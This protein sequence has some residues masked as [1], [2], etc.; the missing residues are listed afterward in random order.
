MP[1]RCFSQRGCVPTRK[2]TD[3]SSRLLS[4]QRKEI[5]TAIRKNKESNAVLT[6]LNSEL[7]QQFKVSPGCFLL[8]F[9]QVERRYLRDRRRGWY[10]F[11]DL[12]F[13]FVLFNCTPYM[14]S[15]CATCRLVNKGPRSAT[16]SVTHNAQL[17][18]W[19]RAVPPPQ[20]SAYGTHTQIHTRTHVCNTCCM[21]VI[22]L[23]SDP[24]PHKKDLPMHHFRCYN[25]TTTENTT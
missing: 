7:Q 8:L 14:K 5:Q 23:V 18:L 9:S 2:F 11:H 6:R 25:T 20:G 4:R 17:S 12:Q 1:G 16:S 22:L 13:H 10:F 3:L 19:H 24:V 21:L 15:W